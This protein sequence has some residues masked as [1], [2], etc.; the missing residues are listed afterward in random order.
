MVT[1]GLILIALGL[2]SFFGVDLWPAVLIALGGGLL[3]SAVSGRG[4]RSARLFDPC[5]CL[6]IFRSERPQ[7]PYREPPLTKDADTP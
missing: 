3:V 7:E 2:G 5:A 4:S 1:W 6:P